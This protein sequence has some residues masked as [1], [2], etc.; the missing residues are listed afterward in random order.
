MHT[1]ESMGGSSPRWRGRRYRFV[2]GVDYPVAHPRVG[3]DDEATISMCAIDVGSSPRWR[4]RRRQPRHLAA[5][6][7]LIP[8]LAGTTPRL[9]LSCRPPRAHPRVGGDDWRIESGGAG[10]LGS[11]PRWLGRPRDRSEA[12]HDAGLIPALAGT[13]RGEPVHAR[14]RPGLIPAL[15]GTTPTDA[16]LVTVRRAHPRVGGDDT[17]DGRPGVIVSGSSPRWRGR[18]GP[19]R[20]PC[21]PRGLIPALAGTTMSVMAFPSTGGAHPRVGGDDRAAGTQAVTDLGSSP[22]WRGRRPCGPAAPAR[23]RL[24]PAL[25]GTTV[26]GP[27]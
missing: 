6:H 13:T 11:S 17:V 2:R 1:N 22:R 12:N 19:R 4:G 14:H 20:G 25:A 10:W 21:A 18:R 8:A 26:S 3:G 27:R 5:G 7:G 15:A 16:D 24:I 9:L 23:C